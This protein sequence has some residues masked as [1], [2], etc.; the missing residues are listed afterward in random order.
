V[1]LL[2]G[3][4]TIAG[5][6]GSSAAGPQDVASSAGHLQVLPDV[7]SYHVR[8]VVGLPSSIVQ[9]AA[10]QFLVSDLVDVY[11]L[12][13]TSGGYAV[14]R[15]ARPAV[16]AW[17]PSGLAFHDGQLYIANGD[18]R[19]V[20]V[21]RLV[22]DRMDLVRRIAGAAAG[23]AQS[24]AVGADG[25]VAVTDPGSGALNQFG[26]DG[27]LRWRM[28]IAGAY[29]VTESG[30]SIFAS[31]RDEHDVRK[32]DGAGNVLKV[33]GALGT[34]AGRFVQPIGLADMGDRI[35]VTDAVTGRITVLDHDLG[36]IEQAGGTGP[37]LDALDRPSATLALT[38]GYLIVDTN[39]DR[40]L[41]TGRDWTVTEQIALGDRVA[42][43]RLRPAVLA[44]DA[45]PFTYD[46]LPGV[47][48]ASALRLRP[49]LDFVGS[50]N[51]LDHFGSDGRH[52]HLDFSDPQLGQTGLTWAQ[53][54][55]SYVV[56]G[57]P[58]N[59][60][61]EVIDPATGMFTYVPVGVDQWWRPGVL[62]G[63]DNVRRP[64][65]DVIR[66][67]GRTF[68]RARQLQATGV[69]CQD[70]FSSALGEFGHQRNWTLDL[71]SAPA[72]E[73][74]HSSMRKADATR[75]FDWAMQQQ[76]QRAVELLEVKC[77]SGS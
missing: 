31:S 64:L 50:Y 40:V 76:Q 71:T 15:L 37:G 23:T 46:G 58:Q 24:V 77:L 49:A 70:A 21:V 11:R 30:G 2:A 32:I 18:S 3:V 57:S 44:T 43:G 61:L 47:D 19:D 54:V 45:R 17:S 41:R 66:P 28:Q 60:S 68:A 42:A 63:T 12:S 65:A 56:V 73:F 39:K 55:G 52:V 16:N 34:S 1:G 6:T 9:V 20:L 67:A 27:A 29:G 7:R 59:P 8:S 48:V 22:D 51:G 13:R 53:R 38:D 69:S 10:D 14:D 72:Q 74:L 5:C 26:P 75:Y 25:S 4:L 35:A 62:L 33:A 36:V